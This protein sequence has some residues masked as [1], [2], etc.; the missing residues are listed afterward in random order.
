MDKTV[1]SLGSVNQSIKVQR[2]LAE[3][4]IP[5]KIIKI[6]NDKRGRG[7]I[8]GIELEHNYSAIVFRLLSSHSIKYN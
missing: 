5:S 3:H 7:C 1:I 8:Y 2:L 4:N 6:S